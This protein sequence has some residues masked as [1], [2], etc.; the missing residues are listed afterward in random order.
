MNKLSEWRTEVRETA[1]HLSPEENL[2][3]AIMHRAEGARSA[4]VMLSGAVGGTAGPSGIYEELALRLQAD[5]ITAIR[6]KYRSVGL[7]DDCVLDAMAAIKA[8]QEQGVQRVVLVGWSFGGAVAIN[9]GATS[10]LVAGVATIAS[11][12]HRTEAIVQLP[13]RNLLLIHGTADNIIPLS[14]A[15]ELYAMAGEPKE[16][17]LY[18]D[19]DHFIARHAV[20]MLEKLSQ[21]SVR[22]CH[23]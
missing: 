6:L 11:Q 19:D 20:E 4:V 23:G 9:A 7:V 2:S 8:L 22:V 1:A 12:K 15:H 10:E 17:V 21:W 5:G 18:Q 3:R 13:P 14:Y 16:L